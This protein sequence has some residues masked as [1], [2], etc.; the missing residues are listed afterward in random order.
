[1]DKATAEYAAT[2]VG[3]TRT[4]AA[5]EQAERD[6]LRARS[7]LAAKREQLAERLVGLYKQNHSSF[8]MLIQVLM[9]ERDLERVIEM[10]PFL[11]RVAREDKD[12]IDEVQAL[13]AGLRETQRELAGQRAR[14][15][16]QQ[17]Q[18]A[19]SR[20]L[21]DRLMKEAAAQREQLKA[22]VSVLKAADDLV[23]KAER[24]RRSWRGRTPAAVWTLAKGFTFPVD[25]P[26]SF[27]DDWGFPRSEGRTH[28]GTDIMA[29]QGTV[30]VAA[31]NGVITR[32]EHGQRLGGTIIWLRGTGGTSY[33]YAHLERILPGV[34]QG[35][36]VEAGMKLATVG[37]TGNAA[38]GSPHL[39]FQVHPGG[40]EAVDP[41]PI[42]RISD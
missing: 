24:A 37:T 9:G 39:H 12:L 1:M 4:E 20:A 11:V 3:V 18:L 16:G 14:L 23:K 29:A 30:V 22:E 35:Q 27:I 21:L 26:H 6:E 40:G 8:P 5:L 13:L 28:K 33:Y 17:K 36:R 2:V 19:R 32:I 34:R 10:L 25:G 15:L 42:L 31:Q 7:D 38:G 41:Y